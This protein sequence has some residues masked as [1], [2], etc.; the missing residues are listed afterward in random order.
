MMDKLDFWTK[1]STNGIVLEKEQVDVF[2]RYYRDLIYWNEKINLISRK[3]IDNIV[4]RHLIHSL[5]ILKYFDIPEKSRI[6]DIGT[7]GGLPGLAIKIALPSVK[8]FLVDSIRK[9]AKTTEMFALHTG[10]RDI[11]VFADRAE[12]IGD[13]QNFNR[14]FDFIIARAVGKTDKLISWSYNYL[15]P[16]GKFI[17][18][19]GGDLSL[20]ID[21]AQNRFS[22]LTIKEIEI[23]FLGI[24]WFKKEEKKLIVCEFSK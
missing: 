14:Y 5:T 20:E 2:E 19:K 15:K 9:K 4:D 8:M 18:L 17:F 22:N 16:S 12:D 3:D 7:G 23:D 11:T 21:D 6:L 1:C 24:D 13:H 10:L